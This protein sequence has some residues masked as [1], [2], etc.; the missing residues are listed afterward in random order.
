MVYWWTLWD[1]MIA[2]FTK[3]SHRVGNG[4]LNALGMFARVVNSGEA[5]RRA[6]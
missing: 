3:V 4:I 6:T 5:A 2:M 1:I